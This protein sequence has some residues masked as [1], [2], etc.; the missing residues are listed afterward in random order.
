MT[1]QIYAWSVLQTGFSEVLCRDEWMKLWDHVLVNQPYWMLMAVVSYSLIN[2]TS[3]LDC[4]E[5]ET[6]KQF[7][8]WAFFSAKWIPPYL[9]SNECTLFSAICMSHPSHL[10][11]LLFLTGSPLAHFHASLTEPSM[12]SIC[13]RVIGI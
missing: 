7:Y 5:L 9:L 2:R 3:L 12:P 8:R 10:H 13:L 1:T 11:S 4:Y 6:F